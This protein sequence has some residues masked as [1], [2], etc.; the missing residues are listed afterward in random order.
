MLLGTRVHVSTRSRKWES[1][2]VISEP[3]FALKQQPRTQL[4]TGRYG[5]CGDW[6]VLEASCTFR[7][8]GQFHIVALLAYCMRKFVR[9]VENIQL[10][11]AAKVVPVRQGTSPTLER[12]AIIFSPDNINLPPCRHSGSRLVT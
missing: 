9:S 10:W 1:Y 2:L 6:R 7:G 3:A 8:E 12:I 5:A 4:R 11:L